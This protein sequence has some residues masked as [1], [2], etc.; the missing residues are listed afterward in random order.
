MQIFIA[1]LLL[2]AL[3][4]FIIYKVNNQFEKREFIILS[5][6]LVITIGGYLFYDKNQDERFPK[7]FKALYLKHNKIDI[8]NLSYELLNN[9]NIS[10]KNYFIYKFTYVINKEGKNSICVMPKVEIEKIGNDFVFKSFNQLKEE[11]QVQ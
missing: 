3:L 6:I 8:S 4:V 11:C 1:F 10:S 9:K 5:I 7:Q 2:L